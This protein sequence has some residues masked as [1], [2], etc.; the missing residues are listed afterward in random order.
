MNV[1]LHLEMTKVQHYFDAHPGRFWRAR[2][3]LAHACLF[4]GI[5]VFSLFVTD[6]VNVFTTL[7][8]FAS[9]RLETNLSHKSINT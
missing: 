6:N 3:H 5:K 8:T 1:L 2:A 7:H 4:V 9:A